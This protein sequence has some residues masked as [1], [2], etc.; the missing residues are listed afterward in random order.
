MILF[1]SIKDA[2]LEEQLKFYKEKTEFLQKQLNFHPMQCSS[3]H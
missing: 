1:D 2:S 3:M